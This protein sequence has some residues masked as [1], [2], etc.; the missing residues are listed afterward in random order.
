MYNFETLVEEHKEYGI[1]T[2]VKKPI[3][4]VNGLP[5]VQLSEIVVT[6][7]GAPGQVIALD[8]EKVELLFFESTN[9]EVGSKVTRSGTKLTIPVSDRVLGNLITPLGKNLITH[10]VPQYKESRIIDIPPLSIKQRAP[11]QESLFT[12]VSIVDNTV[13]LGK[14]QRELILGDRKT[15]KTSFLFSTLKTQIQQGSI[16]IYA[17]IGKK[18][19]EIKRLQNMLEEE[20]LLDQVVIVASRADDSP[21]LI[22][23]TPFSAMTIAEYFR[24]S[25]KNCLVILDDLSTHAKFYREISLVAGRFPGRDSYPGDIFYTH[26]RLLERAGNYNVNEEKTAAITCLPVAETTQND[27][28]DYIV[29]N[30]IGITDGHLLFDVDNFI[31]GRRPA[32][33]PFLS[34]TRVGRQTQS[35]LRQEISQELIT[36]L[37]SYEEALTFSHF[38]AELTDEIRTTLKKG[39]ELYAFF[40]QPATLSVPIQ[41]QLVC[42]GL[43]WSGI[44]SKDVSLLAEVRNGLVSSYSENGE[45]GDLINDITDCK[46]IQTLLKNVVKNK[47]SLSRYIT[48]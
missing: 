22:Y 33:N 24:D 42:F 39:S 37:T 3:V 30:L 17:M 47:E 19:N 14:G 20:N 9:I 26:A 25:G 15:G 36:F 28:S 44:F 40:D 35:I 21:S 7:G 31:K 2:A 6:E 16:V 12:G 13:P 38:G 1:V 23:I 48:I 29:S 41:V 43:I 45:A 11:V 8:E 4:I 18:I 5:S 10:K 34:V 27:L 46:D 32:V